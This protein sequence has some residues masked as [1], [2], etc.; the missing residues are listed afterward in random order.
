MK[1]AS[2]AWFLLVLGALFAG[3]GCVNLDPQEDP[4]RFYVLGGAWE[5][6]APTPDTTG[7]AI[8]LRAVQLAS[9]LETPLM[10]VR[11]GPHEVRF[12]E[13]HRWGE[14]LDR[15]INRTVAGNLAAR[16]FVRRVDVV[17]WPAR[18]RFDYEVQLHVLRFEG[19]QTG[20][21]AAPGGT[22]H[23][24]AVWEIMS[25]D[26]RI[27]ARGTTD[28]VGE[29]WATG[30]YEGLAALLDEGLEALAADVLAGLAAVRTP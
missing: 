15:G 11:L 5:E 6:A 8:G 19:V 27:L 16:P 9:Y 28:Y 7:L 23:M 1:N 30:D 2:T 14:D 20:G 21:P 25:P 22:A 13:F 12:A 4:T 17:P 29:G 3:P 18:A 10:V 26:D 24:V